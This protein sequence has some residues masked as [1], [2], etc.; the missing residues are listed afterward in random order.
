MHTIVLVE[1][2]IKEKGLWRWFMDK[3]IDLEV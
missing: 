3:L 1:I 2:K